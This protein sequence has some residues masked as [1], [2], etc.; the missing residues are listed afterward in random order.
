MTTHHFQPTHYHTTIGSHQPVLRVAPGDTVVT[1]TVDAGGRD[2]RGEQVTPGGNPQTGPFFVAGAEPGDTLVVRLDR[3]APNR[4][5]GFTASVL[6]P[7]VVEPSFVK[8][9]PERRLAG[10]TID[11]DGGTATLAAAAPDWE[12]FGP[13]PGLEGFTLPLAPM[14]G[15]FGVA[16]PGGQ[17]ISTATSAEH[18]GNMDYRGFAAGVTAYLPVFVPGA[19]FHLGDGHATQGDGEI[20][21]T[22]IE[23][24]FDVQ[25]TVGLRKGRRIG[26]PRGEN[27]DYLFTA[28][29]ARPLDQALQHATT[30]MVRWLGDEYGLDLRAAS[31]LLGQCVEYEVGNV[32]DPAYTMV[33]KVPKRVLGALA[34]G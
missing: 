19:L 1:T 27:A 30:E 23:I 4:D 18:G 16:P 8:E 21:G 13:V 9:L 22:G 5:Y 7:N 10:W 34:S 17:A 3:L 26:W 28:G 2:A 20:V 24:S 14:L 15:C 31:T 32:F 29:N 11:R 25:F 12:G 33:C 6:A